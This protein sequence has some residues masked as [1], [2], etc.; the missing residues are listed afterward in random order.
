MLESRTNDILGYPPDARLLIINGDD[1]G[2]CHAINEGIL[3]SITNGIVSSTT[4]MT[5]CPWA[6]HAMDMLRDHPDIG[7]GVHLT[8]IS[9]FG[10]FRWGPLASKDKVSSLLDESG[11]FYRVSRKQEVVNR[12]RIDEVELEFRTQI[13]MVLNAQLKPTHLDWHV[14]DEACRDDFFALTVRL[15]KEYDLAMRI[16]SHAAA[17]RLQAEGLPAAEG[18]MQSTYGLNPDDKAAIYSQA[19]R[20]LPAGLSEWSVHPS[21]GNAEAQAMEPDNWRTRRADFEFFTSPEAKAIIAKEGITL[22]NFGELQKVWA[23]NQ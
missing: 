17:V 11:N 20:S 22:I 5:P 1:F 8:L 9:E 18:G 21:L 3:Q 2:M 4:L 14:F 6:F 10:G 7:F 23:R 13:E 15:A 19:L 16:S 12:A